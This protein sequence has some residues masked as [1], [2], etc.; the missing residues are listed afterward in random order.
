MISI[1][2]R[3][4]YPNYSL[5]LSGPTLQLLNKTQWQFYCPNYSIEYKIILIINNNTGNNNNNEGR[6]Y[7]Y[8]IEPSARFVDDTQAVE[9]ISTPLIS[10]QLIPIWDE[11]EHDSI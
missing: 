3:S 11:K 4:S 9:G 7:L 10:C 2:Y 1:T 8:L 6:E 5:H